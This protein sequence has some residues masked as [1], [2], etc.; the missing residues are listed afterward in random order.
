MKVVYTYRAQND[1]HDIY[2]YIA[3][4]LLSPENAAGTARRIMDTIRSLGVMPERYPIYEAEPWHSRGLR[5]AAARSYLIFYMV[6]FQTQTVSI[7]R[8]I[9][10][11]RDIRSQLE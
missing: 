2:E 7:S 1:L 9:Y 11:G 3:F 10:G 8:I 6:D 4:T 5:Y